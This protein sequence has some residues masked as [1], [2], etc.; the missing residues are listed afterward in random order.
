M[1]GLWSRRRSE[2]RP[3][4][5]REFCLTSATSLIYQKVACKCL[6]SAFA[7]NSKEDRLPT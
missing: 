5:E 3:P 6:L 1:A 4:A 7:Q 2:L